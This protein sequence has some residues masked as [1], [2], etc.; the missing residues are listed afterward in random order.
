MYIEDSYEK[1]KKIKILKEL[2]M[3]SIFYDSKLA[4]AFSFSKNNKLRRVC[5]T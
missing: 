5:F 1:V 4:K 2:A 3:V